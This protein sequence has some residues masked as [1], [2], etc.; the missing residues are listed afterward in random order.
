MLD[1]IFPFEFES[2]SI[3]EGFQINRLKGGHAAET[4]TVRRSTERFLFLLCKRG[5]T[6]IVANGTTF[7]LKEGNVFFVLRGTLIDSITV[8]EDCDFMYVSYSKEVNDNHY[9]LA[10][11]GIRHNLMRINSNRVLEFDAVS[12]KTLADGFEN[13]AKTWPL[14]IKEAQKIYFNGI[15]LVWDAVVASW[16]NKHLPQLS[17]SD[18]RRHRIYIQFL[19]DAQQFCTSQRQ[20][21]FYAD[22]AFLT[23]KYFSLLIQQYS[24]RYPSDIIQ[25]YFLIEAKNLLS[26]P[27]LTIQQVSDKLHFPNPSFFSRYFKR[28]TGQSPRQ[29]RQSVK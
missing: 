27:G 14:L 2:T 19:S 1:T 22:R 8:S 7:H 26:T 29:Y 10:T 28:A 3:F 9:A 21:K 13:I 23:P 25:D 5:M 12:F 4:V 24:G 6:D 18:S 20:I 16:A 17:N 15:V 11:P